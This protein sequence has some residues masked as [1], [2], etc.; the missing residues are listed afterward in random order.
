M[1]ITELA[2]QYLAALADGGREIA[3]GISYLDA[4][5]QCELDYQPESL[6]RID[7]L[8]D[9]IRTREA[10]AYEAF[11]KDR[12]NQ[13]FLYCLGFYVGKTIERNNPGARVEWIAHKELAARNPDVAKV[14]TYQFETSV[15]C[16]ITGGS[17]RQG[18][19]LPLSSI[20]IRLFEGPDEKSVWFSA[21][22]YMAS[23]AP[24]T[25]PDRHR[26]RSRRSTTTVSRCGR[27][28]RFS[29]TTAS[30][31]A[32]WTTSSTVRMAGSRSCS[33][34]AIPAGANASSRP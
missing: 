25:S 5:G 20:V 4:L 10:P 8:L 33:T 32:G 34:S 27:G 29:T 24:P 17:A 23:P 19:F 28:M 6:Q 11:L 7:M 14:W 13:N 2:E 31:L 9:Q 3:G 21:D 26:R 18:E 15:I 30:S 1:P 22:A 16:I 12:A